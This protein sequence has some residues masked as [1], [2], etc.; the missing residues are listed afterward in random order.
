M[1][2][3]GLPGLKLGQ[4]QKLPRKTSMLSH[5]THLPAGWMSRTIITSHIQL[6]WTLTIWKIINSHYL[7]RAISNILFLPHPHKGNH[8]MCRRLHLSI[9]GHQLTFR[10]E[11]HPSRLEMEE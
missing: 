5:N 2:K 4:M 3:I 8:C 6:H 11:V 9:L 1:P 7:D 10:M